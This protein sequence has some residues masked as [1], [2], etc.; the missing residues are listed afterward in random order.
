MN[1]PDIL[2][3]LPGQPAKSSQVSAAPKALVHQ[4]APVDAV[5]SQVAIPPTRLAQPVA[6]PEY[7][8]PY[9]FETGY[10]ASPAEEQELARTAA[11]RIRLRAEVENAR[12][13]RRS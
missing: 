10:Y 12:P 6:A 2:P 4:P 8:D 13:K 11:S 1:K 9:L 7:V 5:S 3:M